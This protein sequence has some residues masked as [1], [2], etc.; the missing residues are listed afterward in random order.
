MTEPTLA[1]STNRW[2]D[3]R[4][5]SWAILACVLVFTAGVRFRLRDMPL[6]RDEGEYA[7]AGQS[8]LHGIPPWKG[9]YTMKFPGTS[10]AYAVLMSLFGQTCAGIHLGF[11]LVNGA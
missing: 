3:G 2:K 5:W 1:P 4:A 8:L 9:V 11:L 6:E 10:A 7:Y